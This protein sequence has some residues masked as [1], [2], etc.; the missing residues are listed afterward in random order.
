M[1]RTPPH[2][3]RAHRYDGPRRCQICRGVVGK[4]RQVVYL[5]ECACDTHLIDRQG[6]E[7]VPPRSGIKLPQL[8]TSIVPAPYFGPL[9]IDLQIVKYSSQGICAIPCGQ[10][11]SP[12]LTNRGERWRKTSSGRRIYLNRTYLHSGGPDQHMPDTDAR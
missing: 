4:V 3:E 7:E 6:R 5:D 9:A 1:K 2:Y 12:R 8:L 10:W 11:W